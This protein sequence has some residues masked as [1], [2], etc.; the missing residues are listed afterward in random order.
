MEKDISVGEL[1][2]NNKD[3]CFWGER[4]TNRGGKKFLIAVWERC[5][6]DLGDQPLV[7]PLPVGSSGN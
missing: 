6:I 2:G 7:D 1:Q 4:S 3:I 5:G